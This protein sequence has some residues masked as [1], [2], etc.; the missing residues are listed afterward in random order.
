MLESPSSTTALRNQLRISRPGSYYFAAG[1]GLGFGLSASIGVQLA[2][3]SRPVVCVLGEGSA[4]YAITAFW[5]AAAYEVP[6]KFLVLRNND[7][8]IL[9]WF[10]SLEQVEGAPA[11]DLPGLDVA[12]TAESYGVPSTTRLRA[13]RAAR[14]P[15]DGARAQ[16]GRGSC[17]STWSP[18]VRRSDDAARARHA[19][20][21]APDGPAA[22][23]R[24]PDAL[25]AGTPEPLRGELIALLGEDRVLA[26]AID[27]VRYA[28]DAS[29]YRLFPAVVVM[30]HDVEDVAKVLAYARRTGTPVN[31]RGGGTSLNGQGADRR[32]PGRRAPAMVVRRARPWTAGRACG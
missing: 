9:K 14:G 8:S 5:T 25:A 13:R 7:Y 17:R 10:A 1:G 27:L 3:P 29:P 15:D 4:Q 32:D 12:A 19:P 2:Q 26:R 18:D 11:L 30:A 28:S 21:R 24:A 23:D 22:P 20:H 6:V 16:P 31:F